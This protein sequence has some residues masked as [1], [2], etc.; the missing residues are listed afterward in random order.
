MNEKCNFA[1]TFKQTITCHIGITKSWS[2]FQFLKLW[3]TWRCLFHN[4]TFSLKHIWI[5]IDLH[6]QLNGGWCSLSVSLPCF[7]ASTTASAL[8]VNRRGSRD[9]GTAL[10]PR[11]S[12]SCCC[13]HIGWSLSP[14]TRTTDPRE[15]WTLPTAPGKVLPWNIWRWRWRFSTKHFQSFTAKQQQNNGAECSPKQLTR[16]ETC[17]I[18]FKNKR[19][20]W[21]S[22]LKVVLTT[23]YKMIRDLQAS[24][25]QLLQMSYMS[26]FMLLF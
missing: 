19:C 4:M 11:I 7:Q 26:H 9:G 13:H 14:S 23:A 12:S 15:P 21:I 18:L 2:Q 24:R 3:G 17:F 20:E 22:A 5:T 8:A 25:Q 6:K 1:G 10:G 16:L